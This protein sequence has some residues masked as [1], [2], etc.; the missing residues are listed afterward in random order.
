MQLVGGPPPDCGRDFEREDS[1][2]DAYHCMT[3]LLYRARQTVFWAQWLLKAP[4]TFL[5]L[6]GVKFQLRFPSLSQECQAPCWLHEWMNEWK[7]KNRQHCIVSRGRVWFTAHTPHQTGTGTMHSES[8]QRNR[9]H[10]FPLFIDEKWPTGPAFWI[11]AL[12]PSSSLGI[13]QASV[14]AEPWRWGQS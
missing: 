14:L 4:S 12:P 7:G 1:L 3:P 13:F 5:L 9:Y 11:G 6:L 10:H 8:S 2:S